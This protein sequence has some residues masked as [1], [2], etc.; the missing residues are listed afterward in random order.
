VTTSRWR[1]EPTGPALGLAVASLTA[2]ALALRI[3]VA[4]QDLFADELAT[5]WIVSTFGPRSLVEIVGTTAEI[6]PPLSFLASW[7]TS[8]IALTPEMV[9]LPALVAG[10]ATIP[11]V[12]AVG[13]RTVGK[14]AALL[15]AAITALGPFMIFY[16]A[17]ARGY[18]LMMALVLVSTLAL[19]LAVDRGQRRW[20]VLYGAAVLA[21]ALTHYTAIFV[22]VAQFTW[23]VWAHPGAARPLLV[24]TGTAAVLYL[25][26]VPSLLGDIDS[27][28][29]QLLAALLPFNVETLRTALAHWSIGFPYANVGDLTALPGTPALLLIGAALAVG[30]T[31]LLST[32]GR[33][34]AWFA[35]NGSRIVLVAALALAAPLGA[36]LVSLV[37][38]DIFGT[39][40][41]AASWPYAALAVAALITVGDPRLRVGASVLIVAGFALGASKMLTDDFKRPPFSEAAAYVRGL[42]GDVVVVDA[43]SLTPGPLAN[44]DVAGAD[45]H[46]PVIRLNVP[47][48]RGR[49]FDFRH[50]LTELDEIVERA[51]AGESAVVLVSAVQQRGAYLGSAPELALPDRDEE[52]IDALPARYEQTELEVFPGLI[53]LELRLFERRSAVDGG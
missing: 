48:V 50:R 30:A 6:T 12:Y 52:L 22:L 28:T 25:P 46:A 44:F 33:I 53:D 7:L 5:Y 32:R 41:L 13:A 8:K 23:V 14:G 35:P 36:A 21:V 37:A 4:S 26:W 18:G 27:P 19:L 11:L 31:G 47:E 34:G 1:P 9:R 49:P 17:E 20:W 29:T 3:P 40:N 24:A 16:S 51:T 15:A 2:L 45:P 39:R 10:T 42:P 38:N 43:A